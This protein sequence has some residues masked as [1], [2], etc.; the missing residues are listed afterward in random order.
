MMLMELIA[1]FLLHNEIQTAVNVLSY[2]SSV[3]LFGYL[4]HV[5][6]CLRP[7]G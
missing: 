3:E 4:P 2:E 7:E 1:G 5:D 6:G